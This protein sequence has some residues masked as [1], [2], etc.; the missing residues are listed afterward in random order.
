MKP[1]RK[2]E[3]LLARFDIEVNS[4]QDR[5][6]LDKLLDAQAERKITGASLSV[7]DAFRIMIRSR[8]IQIMTATIIIGIGFF[9]VYEWGERGEIV[10]QPIPQEVRSPADLTTLG[11]L[12]FAYCRGGIEL[13]E[14]I[15][16]Q[17]ISRS[18]P[19]PAE[20]SRWDYFQESNNQ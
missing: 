15:C 1:I 6:V 17:A 19:R 9:S 14:K 16:D 13:V 18:G 11:A 12:R 4:Q 8:M 20:I 10:S 7:F 3:K 5:A 2:I